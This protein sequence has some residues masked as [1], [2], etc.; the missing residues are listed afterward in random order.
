MSSRVLV[1]SADELRG[2]IIKKVLGRN[3]FECLIFSRILEAGGE[4]AA[5]SPEVVI[6]DTEGALF[7]EVNHLKNICQTLEH[8][9]TV[10]LG[11]ETVIDGFKGPGIRKALCV[12][13]PFDPD[14]I[15]ETIKDIVSP[16]KDKDNRNGTDV[17][18][19]TLRQLLH[20]D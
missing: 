3:G 15:A 13:D 20:L 12:F 16:V 17:L 18:E 4:I 11:K 8:E 2:R 1:I 19:Q 7:E 9:A 6:L 10:V 14:R 5:R